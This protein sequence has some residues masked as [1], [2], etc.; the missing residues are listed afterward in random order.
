MKEVL[1]ILSFLALSAAYNATVGAHND[2]TPQQA[3]D[4]IDSNSPPIVV[5]VREQ[6]DYCDSV[7][8]I[9]GALN[10][11]WNSGILRARYEE[12]PSDGAILVYCRTGYRSNLAAEFLDSKGFLYVYDMSGGI[13]AWQWGKVS[14]ID[15][16]GDRVNDDLDNCPATYNPSQTDSD[17]D[18]R[19][20]TC[21]PNCPNLDGL[22]PVGF[23]D[24]SVLA[25]NWQEKGP[26]LE[27]DLNTDGTV[28]AID[29]AILGDY[30]LSECYEE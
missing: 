7:G 26:A 30:W 23:V 11:P 19:G 24:F 9:P 20:N 17:G 10:Y 21:D 18:G 29:L 25:Q 28:D 27:G 13:S 1:P 22:N 8:H 4:M 14:C 3:K 15:S 5:D 2:V 6:S 16:D 12:L